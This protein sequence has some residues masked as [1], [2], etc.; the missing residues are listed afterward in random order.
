MTTQ[1]TWLEIYE[2]AVRQYREAERLL[3][4]TTTDF[5][6]TDDER[7]RMLEVQTRAKAE[8]LRALEISA[9]PSS[10]AP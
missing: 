6:W 2:Q 1:P 3:G 8:M 4:W 9:E 5:A 7:K 10:K